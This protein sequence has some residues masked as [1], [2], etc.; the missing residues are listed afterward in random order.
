MPKP[1]PLNDLLD[2]ADTSHTNPDTIV[3]NVFPTITSQPY[4]IA[5]IGEA[6]GADEI[7][8]GLPFV[9]YSGRFLNDKLGRA[10]I[11]RAAC[12]I[13]NVCQHRPP[14]NDITKFDPKGPEFDYGIQTLEQDLEK[15]QPNL[16]ILLGK[17]ALLAA[18]GVPNIKDWR[19][20]FF[21]GTHGP[22]NGRKC[23]ATYHPA[24]CLRMYEFAPLLMFDLIKA[25]SQGGTPD[26][27]IPTRDLVVDVDL[28]T[29]I[30]ELDRMNRAEQP[31]SVDIEGYVD[32]MTCVSIAD[33]PTHS[34]IVPFSG[35]KD[36]SYWSEDD[37][38]LVWQ[39]F[40]RLMSN[41]KVGKIFQNGMY[42]RFVL[43]YS[44]GIVVAGNTDDTMLKHWELYA[45]LKKSLQLQ[46]SL[47][48]GTQP[49][50]KY[51]R[52]IDDTRVHHTYCCT[53]SAVT[54]EISQKLDKWL[55]EPTRRHYKF[56][57]DLLHPMLFVEN[58]GLLYDSKLAA[59]RLKT[60]DQE[61]YRMQY[62]MDKLAT[63]DYLMY[64]KTFGLDWSKDR[65]TLARECR[66]LMG[67]KANPSKPVKKF[68]PVYDLVIRILVGEMPI[69]DAEKGFISVATGLSMNIRTSRR[70]QTEE[71]DEIE[72]EGFDESPQAERNFKYYLYEILHLPPQYKIDPKTKKERISTDY[73]SLLKLS[74]KSTHPAIKLAIEIGSLRTRSQMLHILCDPDGRVRAG[75]NVVGSETGRITCR[76]SPTGSG[77]NLTTIPDADPLEADSHPLRLGMRDL[78]LADPGC[79][80]GKCDLKGADGW[81]VG[82]HLARLSDRSMLDDL[83]AGVKPAQVLCFSMRHGYNELIG[84]SREE[85][86]R[87]VSEVK[88][89]NW[90]YFA[91][92]QCIWGFCYLM[93]ARKAASHIFNLSRGE[94]EYTEAHM[95]EAKRRL[96]MRYRVPLWWAW[97]ENHLRKQPYPPTV[98]SASGQVRKFFNRL[99]DALGEALAHEPQVNTTYATNSAAR[100]LWMDPEN[101]YVLNSK[102]D[103]VYLHI[104]PMHQV[105]D[106]LLVQWK[107]DITEWAVLK[108]KQYFNNPITIAGQQITIP[109]DG[110][111]GLNW[112]M[113]GDAK[114]GEIR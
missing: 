96:F 18:R 31:I 10:G 56:N 72:V 81:T 67:W 9:G 7:R 11:L 89:E 76:T 82:A 74:K 69:T 52:K 114:K 80:L 43:Q 110:S 34:V 93:G 32:A 1:N 86:K 47:Y 84:K 85:V 63:T 70:K 15:F 83:Y 33:S 55:T 21:L 79:Y 42:D 105:H 107:Q 20:T 65:Q 44:Y 41:P 50:Y 64:G 57:M 17:T 27:V 2:S 78:I 92:K 36:G 24:A 49:Y 48:C 29:V 88:K 37:E 95:E 26:L 45:E 109:F 58:E 66:A 28:P 99:K 14:G 46:V 75:Y 25:K 68:E 51:Q 71:G 102:T 60:C 106:E 38:I 62:Q 87:L 103:K 19:G 61:I 101:R 40:A 35:N 8:E 73:E 111:Y 53:D 104:R 77:Y 3:P 39:S 108:M 30:G 23:I 97:M 5:I 6:P 22:F 112:S 54:Y 100:A 13:G 12:Y 16:C 90:D 94:V 4:R 59:E 91:Y 98:G 113:D